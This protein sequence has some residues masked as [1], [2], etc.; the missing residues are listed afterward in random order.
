LL[1]PPLGPLIE[2]ALAALRFALSQ[3]GL[4]I[5]AGVVGIA[6][7]YYNA[8]GACDARQAAARAAETAAK[9]EDSARR[10]KDAQEAARRDLPR[11]AADAEAQL[12][13]WGV[14][15]DAAKEAAGKRETGNAGT[16]SDRRCAVDGAFARR[17]LQ[18]DRAGGAR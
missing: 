15:E 13:M 4:P 5:V 7:G 14:I 9:A 1:I 18:H 6:V 11:L 16:A 3:V 12:A 8:D 10:V 2:F 17:V